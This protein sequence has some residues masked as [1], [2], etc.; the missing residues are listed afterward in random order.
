MASLPRRLNLLIGPA[1]DGS[2]IPERILLS[3]A[4]EGNCQQC[5]ATTGFNYEL[6]TVKLTFC[7]SLSS[8]ILNTCFLSD[9]TV[10]CMYNTHQ[11]NPC[12]LF[13]HNTRHR[14]LRI[15]TVSLLRENTSIS[16]T[17]NKNKCNKQ[18]SFLRFFSVTTS[19]LW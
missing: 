8:H 15:V 16:L 4:M 13:D 12:F 6:Y 7:R 10:S 14:E 2:W 19:S 9:S 18:A 5:I 11:H 1:L 3:A 17:A